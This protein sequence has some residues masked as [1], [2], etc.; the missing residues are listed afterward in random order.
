MS[1]QLAIRSKRIITSQGIT[2]GVILI[3]DGKILD[4]V[5]DATPVMADEFIDAGNNA[6][7]AGIIDPHVHINEPGRTEWEGFET[8]TKAAAAGGITTLIDMPLNSSPVTTTLQNFQLK[9]SAAKKGLY[10]NC[11]FYGGVIPGNENDLDALLDAGVFG[12]KAF[13][14]HSGIDEFPNASL[15]D[16][17]QA[18]LHLRKFN[19]PLLV[20]CEWAADGF[21]SE[22]K[23]NPQSYTAYLHSRPKIWEDNAIRLMIE[24]SGKTGGRLHV[25]H[26]S[27]ADSIPQL[28]EAIAKKIPVSVETCSH[29]LFFNA[30]DIPDGSPIYK[31]APPIREKENNEKLWQALKSGLLSFIATDHSPAPPE[32]KKLDSGNFETAWGGIAG[33]QFSL[34]AVWKKASE[35]G[36][37]LMDL[38]KWFCENPAKF[39]GLENKKGTIAKGMD[40]D[41]FIFD[42]EKEFT[43]DETSIYHRHKVS[44]YC[45]HVLKGEIHQT[46][47][48]G[49]KVF[50]RGKFLEKAGKILLKN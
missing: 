1:A 4:I 43:P 14:V 19:R 50:D 3:Q 22:L 20:H 37:T 6:V 41:L 24:L 34:P 49:I 26:L 2:D 15:N 17:E 45:G 5:R 28:E 47:V 35:R 25:V 30:E 44:A 39:L 27:S 36:F 16:V 42:P 31:C 10:V 18:L 8:A 11:G 13:L 23:K 46:F 9:L 48:N 40:A 12:L 29:Y 7:M 38:A 21:D 33:L 32:I